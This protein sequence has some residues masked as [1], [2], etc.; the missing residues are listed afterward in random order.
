[1]EVV[2]TGTSGIESL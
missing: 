1:V 2:F